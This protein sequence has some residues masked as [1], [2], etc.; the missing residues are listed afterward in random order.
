M[1]KIFVSLFMA[2]V[3][4]I[5]IYGG[6]VLGSGG[7]TIEYN[8]IASGVR[9]RLYF[10]GKEN[11]EGKFADYAVDISQEGAGETLAAYALRDNISPMRTGYTDSS[12][13]V[14]FEISNDGIY[15]IVSDSFVKGGSLYEAVPVVADT[16]NKSNIVIEGKYDVSHSSGGKSKSLAVMKVWQGEHRE[17]I[18]VQLLKDGNVVDE[19][20][21]NS[22]N[23]W[24]NVWGNLDFDHSYMAV[25][26]TVPKGYYLHIEKDGD[27]FIL[28]N[29]INNDH[30]HN[31]EATTEATTEKGTEQTTKDTSSP[32]VRPASGGGRIIVVEPETKGEE[33]TETKAVEKPETVKPN[34]PETID[35]GNYDPNS[36]TVDE[37]T[38]ENSD[39]PTTEG[40]EIF[41][42]PEHQK[43]RSN[44]PNDVNKNKDADGNDTDSGLGN[45]IKNKIRS[46]LPQTGQLWW[47]VPM[48]IFVGLF[49][50]ILGL[51]L[52]K[53]GKQVE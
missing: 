31:T 34:E 14:L 3:L 20:I 42:G 37:N 6:S 27:V 10:V 26:K 33:T 11:A 45:D 28:N 29:N 25:E 38:A 1:K 2:V 30:P 48:L 7:K 8:Y 15:L 51:A 22:A 49:L 41:E 13:R 44:N 36:L 39:E 40:K 43:L 12:G 19:V 52:K 50:M 23:N 18:S 4:G 24:R 16:Q 47:P 35:S 53:G 9:V 21:L 5:M 17:D 32:A 46:M